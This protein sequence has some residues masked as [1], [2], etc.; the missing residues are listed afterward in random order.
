MLVWSNI[1]YD[2]IAEIFDENQV[3]DDFD[4]TTWNRLESDHVLQ[5]SKELCRKLK[6]EYHYFTDT[7]DFVVRCNQCGWIGQGEKAV[8]MHSKQTGHVA[9]EEIP[10]SS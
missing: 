4:V 1:H 6:E 8:V 9:I 2:R 10:D 5:G 7:S 3:E